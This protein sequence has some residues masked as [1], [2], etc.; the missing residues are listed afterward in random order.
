MHVEMKTNKQLQRTNKQTKSN[1]TQKQN[2]P[3]QVPHPTKAIFLKL[4]QNTDSSLNF[5]SNEKK[6]KNP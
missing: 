2:K 1:N 6:K 3:S 5:R 4:V